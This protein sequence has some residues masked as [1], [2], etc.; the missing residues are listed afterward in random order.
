MLSELRIRNFAL[1]DQ[2]TVQ[3][4]PGLNVLTGETGAGKS[5]IVGAL[6]LLLGE[7]A[8]SEVVRAGSDRAL[9]EGVFEVGG[10]TDVLQWLTEHGVDDPDGL[11]ILRREVAAEGRSRGWINGSP[12][13]VSLLSELGSVLVSLHGQHQHQR[14]LRRDEQREILDMYAGAGVLAA[15][16]ASAHRARRQLEGEI[17]TLEGRRRA[18]IQRADFLRFQLTEIDDAS[19]RSDEEDELEEESR[20]LGHAEEL[21]ELAETLLRA[22]SSSGDSASARLGAARRPLDQLIRIDPTQ[23]ELGELH[24]TAYFAVEE[25]SNRLER[26]LEVVEHDPDRLEEIRRRQDLL[27]RLRSKY[28]PTLADVLR[29]AEEARAELAAIDGADWEIEAL[30]RRRTEVESDLASS[31]AALTDSRRAAAGRLEAEVDRILPELGMEGGRF[32]IALVS[33]PS[34]GPHGNEE[35][36]FRVALNRGFDPKPIAQVASGGELSRV[37]LALMTILAKLES[38]PTLIFDEVDAGI[39]GRVA[40]DVGDKMRAVASSHQVLAIT[41]LPQIASRAHHHLLVR[42]DEASGRT[43]TSVSLLEEEER[44]R[45]LARMLGGDSESEASLTHAREL[46]HKGRAGKAAAGAV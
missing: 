12:A 19:V 21:T 34:T 7:R 46:L 23:Q 1:I 9:V 11:V 33:L 35:V 43:T 44:V 16:V 22:L 20:R 2:L 38:V 29:T 32:Q 18:A 25:L 6:S 17:D 14:L 27:F 13:T 4:A 5:I 37:M 36:E 41:H 3:L 40:L 31:A 8:S 24:D 15:E 42:K 10:R 30:R 45:E 26:Y 39:G 28:G